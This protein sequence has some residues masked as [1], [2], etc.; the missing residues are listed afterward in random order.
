MATASAFGDDDSSEAVPDAL[1]TLVDLSN[2]GLRELPLEL[3]RASSSAAARLCRLRPTCETSI[4]RSTGS[5][6]CSAWRR[7]RHG[8]S[9]CRPRT[10]SCARSRR[11]SSPSPP[12]AALDLSHNR[13][14]DLS[15]LAGLPP[16]TELWVPSNAIELGALLPLATLPSLRDLVLRGNLCAA[17]RPAGIGRATALALLPASRRSTRR[18]SARKRGRRR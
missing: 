9:A 16:L 14:A 17:A 11:A 10:T 7:R 3:R 18:R 5:P 15:P 13:L 4:W 2:R 8:W 6:L 1:P 12:S